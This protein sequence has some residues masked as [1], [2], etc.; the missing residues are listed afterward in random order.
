MGHIAC[1]YALVYVD[2][3]GW[4]GN[5]GSYEPLILVRPEQKT[6]SSQTTF[7]HA[8][9]SM[10]MFEFLAKFEWKLLLRPT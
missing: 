2:V 7:L 6:Q 4:Q 5:G 8:F 3:I 10:E 1:L 9:P